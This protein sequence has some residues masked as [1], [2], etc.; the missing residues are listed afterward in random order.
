MRVLYINNDGGGF[1]DYVNVHDGM[2]VEQ[3]V[4]EIVET[5]TEKGLLSN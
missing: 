5:P 1:A 2:T 3:C 4:T